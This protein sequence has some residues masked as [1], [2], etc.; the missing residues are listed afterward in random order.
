MHAITQSYSSGH[1]AYDFAL[2]YEQVLAADTGTIDRVRWYNNSPE[3]HGPVNNST[4]GYGLHIYLRH[5]N[6]YT[7]RYGH[8]SATAFDLDSVTVGTTVQRGQIIGTS[9]NTGW[10]TGAHL[11]FEV[12]D[13]NG[14]NVDPIAQNLWLDGWVEGVGG[15]PIPAP[16]NGGETFVYVTTDNTGGFSKGNG[17]PFNNTCIGNCANWT[18]YRCVKLKG[19]AFYSPIGQAC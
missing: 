14:G 18:Y 13:A 10:S 15:R 7:T 17:G 12:K 16:I 1:P 3:C 4:C 5:G 9:G 2:S 11:H 8:L 6:G 19:V